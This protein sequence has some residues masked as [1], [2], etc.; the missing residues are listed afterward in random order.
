MHSERQV[1]QLAR[2]KIVYVIVEGT[3]DE[4]ALG[5]GLYQIFDKD[6][7]YIYIAH[8]DITTRSHTFSTNIV[9]KIGNMIKQYARNNHFKASDFR[10]IIHIVDTDGVYIPDKMVQ[11]DADAK[12]TLYESDGIHTNN[13]KGIL[14]RNAVKRDN[15]FRLR[16]IGTIWNIP[17]AIYYMSCNLDHVLYD[18]RNSTDE[19]KE[20]DAYEFAGKYKD[21][22]DGFASYLCESDFSVKGSYK[23]TWNFIEE[24]CNSV[25]RHSNLGICIDEEIQAEKSGECID[26][27]SLNLP[28][29]HISFRCREDYDYLTCLK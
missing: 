16:G 27:S 10:Q 7:V 20:N 2:K 13:V 18:K 29:H 22:R 1:R 12:K 15:L 9:A 11:E 21:D 28:V 19:E 6:S 26:A 4:T 17:Y 8:G 23:E 14:A 3:S 25:E 24:G 5:V